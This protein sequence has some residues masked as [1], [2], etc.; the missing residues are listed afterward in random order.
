MDHFTKR[1]MHK[2]EI[3][4]LLVA[5]IITSV[6]FLVLDQSDDNIAEQP[7]DMELSKSINELHRANIL[8]KFQNKQL[9]RKFYEAEN[10][11]D[12][13]LRLYEEK[14]VVNATLE[15]KRIETMAAID[16]FT[17]DE[18]FQFFAGFNTDSTYQWN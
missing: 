7:Y 16:S 6:L 1:K 11:A 9:G 3:I 2:M 12:S 4:R 5:V 17:G 10:S 8:L 15:A 18:L 13:L 14:E